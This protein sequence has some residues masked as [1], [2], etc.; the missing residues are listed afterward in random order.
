ME[1][2][3][4]RQAPDIF[5]KKRYDLRDQK[6]SE[7]Y[8]TKTPGNPRLLAKSNEILRNNKPCYWRARHLADSR[9]QTLI[10]RCQNSSVSREGMVVQGEILRQSSYWY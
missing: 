3:S 9:R 4:V 1:W 6:M 10:I 5:P 2:F 8:K 7:G